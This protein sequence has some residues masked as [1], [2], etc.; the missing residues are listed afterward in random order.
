MSVV[1]LLLTGV[2]LAVA[3]QAIT[4]E[5]KASFNALDTDSDGQISKEELEA[6][7]IERRRSAHAHADYSTNT[8]RRHL[9]RRH[10]DYFS[11]RHTSVMKASTARLPKLIKVRQVY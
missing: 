4:L 2:L 1:R 5:P 6:F 8:N 7:M 3:V 9:P 10:S 11:E